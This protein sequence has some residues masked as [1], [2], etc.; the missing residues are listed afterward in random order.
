MNRVKPGKSLREVQDRFQAAILSGDEGALADLMDSSRTSRSVLFGVYREAYASRLV[1][2]IKADHEALHAYLG[3]EE[4]DN[5]ARAYV[6]GHPSRTR[7]A[8]WFSKQ[9]PT[10]LL[11]NEPYSAYSEIADLASIEAALN[12][13]FDAQDG[14]IIGLSDLASISPEIWCN[15]KFQPQSAAIRINIQSNAFDIWSAIKYDCDP[16]EP[17]HFDHPVQL[18][19]WRQ[20]FTPMIRQLGTEEAMLWDEARKGVKFGDLCEMA[21][22]YDPVETTKRVAGFLAGWLRA[23]LLSEA[24]DSL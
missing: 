21:A 4:F 6:S 11:N 3:D 22:T 20:K 10:F 2:I 14:P 16:P 15:L 19:V 18:L 7:S 23:D 17:A 9:L 8:R 5:L 12:S 13:A 24:R 1:E